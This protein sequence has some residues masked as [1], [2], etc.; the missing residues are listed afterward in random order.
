LFIPCSVEDDGNSAASLYRKRILCIVAIR[1]IRTD[2]RLAVIQLHNVFVY[3]KTTRQ[4]FDTTT[5]HACCCQ[6]PVPQ[7]CAT[8]SAATEM[9]GVQT[10]AHLKCFIRLLLCLLPYIRIKV[11]GVHTVVL[12]INTGNNCSVKTQLISLLDY[13]LSNN[14]S[15]NTYITTC[16]DPLGLII[17]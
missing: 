5:A 14:S 11:R 13:V 3:R 2:G 4:A 10:A 12:V 16:F 6:R 7:C 17:R 1:P 8:L 9:F 15:S